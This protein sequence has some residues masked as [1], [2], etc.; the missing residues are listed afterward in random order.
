M[1]DIDFIIYYILAWGNAAN[2]HL[3]GLL[4]V[5]KRVIRVICGATA[6]SHTNIL[7]YENKF[8]RLHNI[9]NF[10]LGCIMY[11]FSKNE[12]PHALGS[13]FIRN[14]QVH[15]HDTRQ[16][17]SFHLP[18][19]RTSFRLNTLVYTGPTLWNSL[20]NSLKQSVSLNVFKCKL[21][22]V[23]LKRYLDQ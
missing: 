21:K 23:L 5:Q 17:S 20:A 22:I 11:Q 3:D 6:R 2:V 9:F 10:N 4:K 15:S 16:A 13:L 7:F 1:R 8:L 18:L 14:D 19:V 12:L